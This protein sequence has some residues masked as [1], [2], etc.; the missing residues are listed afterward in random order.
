MLAT[1]FAAY[2]ARMELVRPTLELVPSY[3]AARKR[4]FSFDM[5]HDP[6][7]IARRTA[8]IEADPET[9]VAELEDLNP[10]GRTLTF[11]DGTVVARLPQYF[12]WMWDGEFAGQISFRFQ[13]GTPELPPTCLGHIGYAVVEWRRGRG[14]ATQALRDILE[15]AR[16]EGLPY[17]EITTDLD[18]YASQ[19][20]ITANGGQ[21]RD[22]RPRL[23]G[24]TVGEPVNTYVIGLDQER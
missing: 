2:D 14:Y 15:L 19:A 7:A 12:R 10:E 4:G 9:F 24:A 8:E 16:A 23:M 6:E 3:L 18:N 21:L 5:D 17:V 11:P 13:R 20:V 1:C 22:S